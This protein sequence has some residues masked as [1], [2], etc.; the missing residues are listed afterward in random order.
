MNGRRLVPAL[1]A[2]S[3]LAVPLAGAMSTARLSPDQEWVFELRSSRASNQVAFTQLKPG[4]ISPDEVTKAKFEVSGA[5]GHLRKA[6]GVASA[7]IGASD[8]E[9]A[10]GLR[11]AQTLT[12]QASKYLTSKN[13]PTA[14]K[15]VGLAMGATDAALRMFGVPLASD[16]RVVAGF[17]E[18]GKVQGWEDYIGLNAK[19]PGTKISKVVIGLAGRETA[20][21]AESGGFRRAP[22]LAITKLAIYTL[23]KPSGEY[24][25]GWGN[26]VNGVIVCKLDPTMAKDETFAISFQPRVPP[27]TKFLVKLQSTDGKRSYAVVTTK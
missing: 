20:N 13:Y 1:A 5:I 27:G 14:R 24:S 26:I 21:A 4:A 6:A 11:D 9:I 18:L 19:A 3:L 10:A 16:F 17:R 25:S 22:S 7:T 23:Q 2:L 15:T 12:A 8:D